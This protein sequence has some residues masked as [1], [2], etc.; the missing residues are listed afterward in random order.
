MYLVDFAYKLSLIKDLFKAYIL[1]IR[2]ASENQVTFRGR[3]LHS[4]W[5]PAFEEQ[6]VLRGEYLLVFSEPLGILVL[7]L[8]ASSS[9]CIRLSSPSESEAGLKI[10]RSP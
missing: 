3:F 6:H 9:L 8:G 2:W 5:C 4:Q 7:Y 10:M 1:F